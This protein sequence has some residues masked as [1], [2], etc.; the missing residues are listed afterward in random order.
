MV[1]KKEFASQ[2]RM[3]KKMEFMIKFMFKKSNK[4]L[5][6]KD[7]IEIFWVINFFGVK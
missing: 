4:N 5:S 7:L 3:V 2:K 1:T 6:P